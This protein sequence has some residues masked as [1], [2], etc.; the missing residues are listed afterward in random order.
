MP[1]VVTRLI[2]DY[3]TDAD[4][5]RVEKTWQKGDFIHDEDLHATLRVN[6]HHH[7]SQAPHTEHLCPDDCDTLRPAVVTKPK[8]QIPVTVS[9]VKA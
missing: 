8:T 2:S 9:E 6:Y 7:L 5:N 3:V 1:A 4:G